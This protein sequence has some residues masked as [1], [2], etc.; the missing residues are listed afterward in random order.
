MGW[1]LFSSRIFLPKEFIIEYEG[2]LLNQADG[3]HRFDNLPEADGSYLF[4][5]GK[6][7]ANQWYAFRLIAYLII[8][9]LVVKFHFIKST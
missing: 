9:S 1:G 3:Q 2:K 4:F 8:M 6:A 5:L 7:Y